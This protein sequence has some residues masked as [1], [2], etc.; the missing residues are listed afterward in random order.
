MST[1]GGCSGNATTS[2]VAP[3]LMLALAALVVTFIVERVIAR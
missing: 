2:L 3:V 1:Q